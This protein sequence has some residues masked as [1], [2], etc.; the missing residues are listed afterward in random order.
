MSYNWISAA[1]LQGRERLKELMDMGKTVVCKIDGAIREAKQSL[2]I[3]HVRHYSIWRVHIAEC[4]WSL[5]LTT[6]L[7]NRVEFLDPDQDNQ[8][9]ALKAENKQLLK[10]CQDSAGK[11]IVD[12]VLHDRQVSELLAEIDRLKKLL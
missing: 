8:I 11:E 5:T 2:T 3:G 9:A 7:L 4:D 6:A 1:T 12:N 10:A